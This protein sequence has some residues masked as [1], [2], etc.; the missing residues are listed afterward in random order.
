MT[1]IL[2]KAFSEAAKLPEVKD[3]A[4]ILELETKVFNFWYLI[5]VFLTFVAIVVTAIIAIRQMKHAK[6]TRDLEFMRVFNERLMEPESLQRRR[7]IYKNAGHPKHNARKHAEWLLLIGQDKIEK[8]DFM[9]KRRE[10]INNIEQELYRFDLMGFYIKHGKSSLVVSLDKW[11]D[12]LARFTVLLCEWISLERY[13]RRGE[14]YLL[15][16]VWLL[17]E[18][19]KYIRKYRP[20]KPIQL[21]VE[22]DDSC[23]NY[24]EQNLEVYD[25]TLEEI[26]DGIAKIKDPDSYKQYIKEHS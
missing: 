26:T 8:K 17:E 5:L 9:K 4:V 22:H 10:A 23:L 13:S 12:V 1:K 11:H 25:I 3:K 16:F 6:L 7:F 2:E 18:N 24:N 15:N 21:K 14:G 19:V 20:K